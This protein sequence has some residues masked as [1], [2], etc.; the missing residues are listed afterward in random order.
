MWATLQS[1]GRNRPLFFNNKQDQQINLV[2]RQ[3]CCCSYGSQLSAGTAVTFMACPC[4]PLPACL[5]TRLTA[6]CLPC[7]REGVLKLRQS[8]VNSYCLFRTCQELTIDTLGHP[9]NPCCSAAP[10]QTCSCSTTTAASTPAPPSWTMRSLTS[11]A[12][13]CAC[14]SAPLPSSP[15]RCQSALRSSTGAGAGWAAMR[16]GNGGA[17]RLRASGSACPWKPNKSGW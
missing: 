3:A 17:S 4:C 13:C 10:E 12:T 9:L 7:S 8:V 15:G 2:L 5:P 11:S 14:G 6:S 16:R 1:A